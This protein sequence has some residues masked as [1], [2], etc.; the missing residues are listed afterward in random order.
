MLAT[1]FLRDSDD[2]GHPLHVSTLR[3]AKL[4]GYIGGGIGGVYG[5]FTGNG[6]SLFG[7]TSDLTFGY[8]GIAGIQY[9]VSDRCDLGVSY[10]FLGTT[11]HDLGSGVAMD[12][13]LT[14][15]FM[16]ALTIKF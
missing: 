5:I 9:A 1:R 10:K 3:P 13:T 14:H 11:E 15:S 7:F 8:Q 16:A 4:R 2:G 12:G 6:T